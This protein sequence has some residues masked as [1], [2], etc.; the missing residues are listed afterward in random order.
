MHVHSHKRSMHDTSHARMP[1][2][3]GPACERDVLAACRPSDKP[4]AL[5]YLGGWLLKS[6]E[7]L[8]QLAQLDQTAYEDKLFVILSTTTLG[9]G[10]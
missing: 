10:K 9:G 8:L 4:Q 3:S 1:L 5:P 6:C 2:R 7:C